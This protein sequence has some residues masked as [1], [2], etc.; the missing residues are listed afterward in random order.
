MG[1]R[2][3]G[4]GWGHV[5]HGDTAIWGLGDMGLGDMVPLDMRH[6]DVGFKGHERSGHANWG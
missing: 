6:G 5:V 4:G 2:G 3:D 1:F